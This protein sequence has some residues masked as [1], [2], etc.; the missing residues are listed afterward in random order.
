MSEDP[1]D[2]H[3][4]E[5]DVIEELQFAIRAYGHRTRS[6][7]QMQRAVNAK[8]IN[9]LMEADAILKDLEAIRA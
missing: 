4:L 9:L 5:Q 7:V 8:A 3:E 1:K 6:D 2:W